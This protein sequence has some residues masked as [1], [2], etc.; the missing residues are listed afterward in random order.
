MALQPLGELQ[1]KWLQSLEQHPERQM[2]RRLGQKSEDGS[3]SACCLGE[4]GLIAGVCEW[5]GSVLFNSTSGSQ[6]FLDHNAY[7]AI[8]LYN[9]LGNPKDAQ[10]VSL[11]H[12]NDNGTTWPEIAALIRKDPSMYFSEPK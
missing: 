8:G 11:S 7:M 4:A 1:E 10:R 2:V 3:Y 6:A 12:L 5:R 9:A